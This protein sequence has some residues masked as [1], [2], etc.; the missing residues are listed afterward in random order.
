MVTLIDALDE[1][2]VNRVVSAAAE[3][4]AL[5]P[6]GDSAAAFERT[7]SRLIEKQSVDYI[8]LAHRV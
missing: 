6:E 7:A 8:R 3:P 4:D 1:R 2:R 5:C